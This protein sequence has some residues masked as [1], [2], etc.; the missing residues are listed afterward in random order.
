MIALVFAYTTIVN[1]VERP[2]GIKI[3]AFFIL[4]IVAVSILSR[5]SR[6]M[7]LRASHV[8]FDEAAQRFIDEALEFDGRL[9]VVPNH[10]ETRD[11]RGV[12]PSGPRGAGGPPPPAVEE[13]I[14]FLEITIDDPSEFD[15]GHPRPG[16]RGRRPPHPARR[17][18]L[19]IPNTI[20]AILLHLRDV[21]GR[22]PHAYFNWTEGNP[23][24]WMLRFLIS[25]TGEIAPITREILRKAERDPDKR[26]GIHAAM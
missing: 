6:S 3:A 23:F 9:R 18:K 10:P 21:S 14:L 25:G 16:R 2:E 12:R 13:P 4:A 17:R 26:P 5:T 24:T 22:R 19:A 11:R 15:D 8:Q 20:A 1:V 7:E